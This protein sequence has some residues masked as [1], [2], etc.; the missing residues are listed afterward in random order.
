[1]I[2][3]NSNFTIPKYLSFT[4][5]TKHDCI[6][7]AIILFKLC[8]HMLLPDHMISASTIYHQTSST[9]GVGLQN[10]VKPYF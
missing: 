2:G 9:G 5:V 3:S 8:E 1:M 4:I 6:T 7:W 10:K